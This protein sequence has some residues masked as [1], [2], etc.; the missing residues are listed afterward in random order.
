MEI[1]SDMATE[2]LEQ[3]KITGYIV[4]GLA[5]I[6]L[7]GGVF[8]AWNKSTLD[9]QN[10]ENMNELYADFPS[11]STINPDN[12]DYQHS[13]RDYYIKT[14][15]NACSAGQ[16]KN[17]FVNV[18]ALKNNI[19]QGARCLDFEVYSVDNKPVIATSSVNDFTVKE[20]FNSVNFADALTVIRDYAF[21]GGTCPNPND[22]LIIHLRIMSN[23][24]PIY[25]DIADQLESEL[26]TRL[27]GPAYSY[28]NQGKN[29]GK[30]PIRNLMGKV[31]ISVDKSNPIF[32]NTK[33]D[34][35]VNIASNSI[36]MRA[37]RYSDGVRYTP[38][39][40]ELIEYNKKNMS[41]CLPDVSPTDF[42]YQPSTAMQCGVQMVGMSMQNFDAN[43]EYYDVFFDKVGSAF[44][45]KPAA[46]RYIPVT[47]PAP[48][49]APESNSYKERKTA[50]DFYSFSM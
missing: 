39:I 46:L 2:A 41:I 1:T 44:V 26:G 15:Y 37:L 16:F 4:L 29:L 24:T 10:C 14:A 35:Y 12:A 36:F 43:L 20:T 49:P 28:E 6:L 3:S 18:C 50:T 38:D 22:P 30:E 23:N 31:I 11:L 13:L 19:R 48:T 47:I 27:L 21:A 32:E 5:A 9:N 25:K 33:L 45:L 40:N 34:E 8:W 42:N 17:D 7:I